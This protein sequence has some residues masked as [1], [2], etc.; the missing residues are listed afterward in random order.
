MI[1]GKITALPCETVARI[2]IY[3]M[4]LAILAQDP[5]AVNVVNVVEQ[6]MCRSV[7]T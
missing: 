6:H 4:S 5:H 3:T 1:L 2:K 7:F